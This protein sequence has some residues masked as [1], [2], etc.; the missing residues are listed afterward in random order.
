VPDG[1]RA[2]TERWTKMAGTGAFARTQGQA[3]RGVAY[4]RL[5]ARSQLTLRLALV[6]F[7]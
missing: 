5:L 3:A 4:A 2:A 1:R 6:G 7:A